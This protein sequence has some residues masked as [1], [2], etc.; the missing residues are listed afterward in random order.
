[1]KKRN[2]VFN[3]LYLIGILMVIDDHCNSKVGFLTMIFP[4]DSFFM[5]LFVFCSGYFYQK[6]SFDDC[7]KKKTKRLL[8]PYII[9]NAVFILLTLLVNKIFGL[10][11]YTNYQ[12][13]VW[14]LSLVY[15]PSS[16]LN[17]I[18]WF[19]VNLFWVSI[20]YNVIYHFGRQEDNKKKD[21]WITIILFLLGLVAIQLCINGWMLDDVRGVFLL[22]VTF[23]IQ[24]Y[25]YGYLFKKYFEEMLNKK[26][27]ILICLTCILINF[28]LIELFGQKISFYDTITMNYF[29]YCFLPI[30]TSITGIVFY[31]ELAKTLA[32]LWS[33][34]KLV[35]FIA[36]NTFTIMEMHLLFVNIPNFYLF[37]KRNTSMK[38]SDFNIE[39]FQNS[40]WY[41]YNTT[42]CI[43]GF[44]CGVIGS[45][46][47]A[48]MIECV[49]KL[50]DKKRALE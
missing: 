22:R 40:V 17:N 36:R 25:H 48:Y 12:L 42:S 32:K 33:D 23:Y 9:W 43:I 24:F 6:L 2:Q 4:Y 16:A 34:S 11:W 37:L 1:M 41:R 44:L 26:N 46:I 5:P 29:S 31:Y 27:S 49:K 38:F 39:E 35:D 47:I 13:P 28:T 7:L 30:I 19:V 8:I 20:I 14:M 45:L 3:W 15:A 50:Y 21:I 10:Y 18:A